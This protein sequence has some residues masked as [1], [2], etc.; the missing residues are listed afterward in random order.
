LLQNVV[1]YKNISILAL[2][3]FLDYKQGSYTRNGQGMTMIVT[4]TF[5]TQR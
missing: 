2:H 4:T 1:Q 3:Y 5:H